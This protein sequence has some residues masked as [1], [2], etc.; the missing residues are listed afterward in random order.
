MAEV[1]TDWPVKVTPLKLATL[2]LLEL[3]LPPL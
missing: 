2:E 1:P 3:K